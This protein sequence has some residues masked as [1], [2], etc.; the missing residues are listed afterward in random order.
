MKL[1]LLVGATATAQQLLA[2]PSTASVTTT[3][4]PPDSEHKKQPTSKR[5]KRTFDYEKKIKWYTDHCVGNPQSRIDCGYPNI[6]AAQCTSRKCC[7]DDSEPG[8][9]HCYQSHSMAERMSKINQRVVQIPKECPADPMTRVD[10]GFRQ[11]TPNTCREMGCCFDDEERGVPWCFHKKEIEI[12]QKLS[13]LVKT[14]M[15][16]DQFCAKLPGIGEMGINGKC[17][18]G[19]RKSS[20][21]TLSCSNGLSEMGQSFEFHC[22]EVDKSLKWVEKNGKNRKP[23]CD[24]IMSSLQP[25]SQSRSYS[26]TVDRFNLFRL[27]KLNSGGFCNAP[28]HPQ[29]GER[30]RC[31]QNRQEGHQHQ[32]FCEFECDEGFQMV[33]SQQRSCPTS[34]GNRNDWSGVPMRCVPST[35]PGRLIGETAKPE[36]CPGMY[37]SDRNLEVACEQGK[38]GN[39]LKCTYSCRDKEARMMRGPAQVT[40][41]K[42]QSPSQLEARPVCITGICRALGNA[43]T[44]YSDCTDGVKDESVC[45][46]RCPIGYR[47]LGQETITCKGSQWDSPIPKCVAD[48][49]YSE[50]TCKIQP[51][52]N[53]AFGH[54]AAQRKRRVV[55][56]GTP[57][58]GALGAFQVAIYQGENFKCGGTLV[59]DLWVLTAAHCLR[60]GNLKVYGNVRFN[61]NLGDDLGVEIAIQHPDYHNLSQF[62]IG[63]IKLKKTI[64]QFNALED[65]A[66][67]PPK[68]YQPDG[69]SVAIYGYGSTHVENM[70][71]PEQLQQGL[72]MYYPHNLC[73]YIKKRNNAEN[74]FCARGASAACQGDSGGP[75]TYDDSQTGKTLLVGVT[76]SG[77]C[78]N[79][80]RPGL[81]VRVSK[82]IDW[83]HDMV[84]YE[85][86]DN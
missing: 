8:V 12:E 32:F 77:R 47:L 19:F 82:F 65:L 54:P 83:I 61:S 38:Y 37:K 73:G 50:G 60:G 57:V 48:S 4:L 36:Y 30:S 42:D 67:L 23:E 44:G 16:K 79:Q 22:R 21:C 68:D 80:Q 59:S 81:Y 78:G 29:F 70:I 66:C 26:N 25:K 27:Q 18:D 13:R 7:Y 74:L 51:L 6:D 64:D 10:C 40:C 55:G 1:L 28:P 71:F 20:V 2:T 58:D 53:S 85:N 62:D 34:N 33:G 31:Y 17:T 43:F 15:S 39:S 9:P 46:L 69:T 72:L 75:V 14:T 84:I 3:Q 86:Y 11:I 76:S 5:Q 24:V 63:L 45:N 35:S 49:L 52:G 56:E 41:N